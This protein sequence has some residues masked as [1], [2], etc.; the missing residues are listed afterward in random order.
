MANE[1]KITFPI[2]EPVDFV[3]V[4]SGSAGGIL[5]REL[6]AGGFRV[7]VLEQ[8]P[9]RT[10]KDFTHDELSVSMFGELRG[11]GNDVHQQT[12]RDDESKEATVTQV[13]PAEYAQTVGGSSVHFTANFWRFRESDFNRGALLFES[14]PR[15]P[16]PSVPRS[17]RCFGS[18]GRLQ[19]FG[20]PCAQK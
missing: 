1:D 14:R 3:I 7:V 15:Q 6:S 16:R 10:A 12:F 4:G 2:D 13:P 11:G 5:A 19:W 20:I 8:G 9:Y 17:G 18:S